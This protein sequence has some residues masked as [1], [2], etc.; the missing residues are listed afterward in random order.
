MSGHTRR[1]GLLGLAEKGLTRRTG[2]LGMVSTIAS[3]C[4][5]EYLDAV[6]SPSGNK[7]A[8]TLALIAQ[9]LARHRLGRDA[10]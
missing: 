2:L 5:P 9:L 10:I 1:A 7:G 8:K 4:N 6:Q 3:P